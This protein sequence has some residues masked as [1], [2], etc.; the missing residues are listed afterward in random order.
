MPILRLAIALFLVQWGFHGWTASL[1]L[2]LA[3]SGAPDASVGLIMGVSAVV[4]IPGAVV[5]GRL[6]DR[7][8]GVRLFAISALAYFAGALV[9]LVAG[10]DPAADL[11]PIVLSR[12]LQGIGIGLSLPSALSLVPRLVAPLRQAGALSYV[13]AAHNT[14]MMVVPAVSLVILDAGGL[15]GVAWLVLGATIVAFLLSRGLPLLPVSAS[16]GPDLAAASR[17]FGITYRR[18]WAMPL[19]I[20][21]LYVAH[22]G[23]VTSYLPIRADAAGASVGLFFAMDGVGIVV[24]R[25]LTGRLTNYLSL[26]ALILVGALMTG[27]AL[28]LL[29][30]PPTNP[31]LVIAGLLGGAGGAIVMTPITIELSRRSSDADRGSAFAL[32]SA[33]LASAMTIGSIGGAPVVAT[34]GYETGLI[35]GIALLLVS[36]ALTLVNRQLA[37][38]LH[39]PRDEAVASG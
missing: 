39:T 23:V 12:V 26:R 4:Q 20:V 24:T 31:L 38:P 14:A 8:G 32:F 21:I 36:V 13:S 37:E 18:A 29:L 30:L 22:W 1:P 9:I 17:R 34:F 25:L 6:L 28:V 27:A 10:A 19:L 35:A 11:G 16:T 3:R 33:G 15:P 5:G 2:A 7:F